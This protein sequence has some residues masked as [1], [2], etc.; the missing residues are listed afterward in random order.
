M[1][2][3]SPP[4]PLVQVMIATLALSA[5]ISCSKHE[6]PAITNST[7]A[8]SAI[9]QAFKEAKPEF[10]AVADEAAAAI[11][12]QPAKALVQL[13]ALSSSPDLDPKQRNA[14]Q[15]SILVLA[16]ELRAAADKGDAEAEKALQ[17]YRASK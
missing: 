6:A 15:D 8:Q 12:A 7:E 10:K 4:K 11:Q 13:Q 17:A 1:T 5:L 2:R 9:E 16:T 3:H 14:T